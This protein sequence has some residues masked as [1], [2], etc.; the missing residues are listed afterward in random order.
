M[1]TTFFNIQRKVAF[2]MKIMATLFML[3]ALFLPHAHPQ[4]YTQLNLPEGAV[5]RLGKG[6][7][8]AIQYSPDGARLAV[9]GSIGIWLYDTTTH[10]EVTLL[11]V[12]T[13][14]VTSVAF[15]PDGT[16]LA[17]TSGPWLDD[18]VRL[19]DTTTGELKKTLTGHT[20]TAF[21]PD[22]KTLASGSGD[23]TVLE[24]STGHTDSAVRLWNTV[25]VEYE[26]TL[27]G[28]SWV[29]GVAFSPDG[30]TLASVSEG[31]TVRLWDAVTGEHKATLIV[32]SWVYGVAF[33]P[34]GKTLASVSEDRTV[35]LWDAVT[36]EHKRTLTGHT[37]GVLSVGF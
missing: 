6:A 21:S 10:K 24:D 16:T 8:N 14:E 11:T 7:I 5:M 27:T 4:E 12:Q 20:S 15:S 3:L 9:A 26:V 2:Q 33:S 31:L 13:G 18:T 36:G 32:H 30:T 29:Y 23:N 19:W 1:P 34:D 35:R 37:D 28:D 25:T 22:G 17:S